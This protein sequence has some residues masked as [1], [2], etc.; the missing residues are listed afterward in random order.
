[1]SLHVDLA[2]AI[3]REIAVMPQ[4]DRDHVARKY[5]WLAPDPTGDDIARLVAVRLTRTAIPCVDPRPAFSLDHAF[6]LLTETARFGSAILFASQSSYGSRSHGSRG[7]GH[8]RH[9]RHGY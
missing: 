3:V 1:M 7:R 8:R 4:R 6:E 5:G 2:D 9:R